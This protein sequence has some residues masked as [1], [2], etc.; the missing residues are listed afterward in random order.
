MGAAVAGEAKLGGDHLPCSHGGI[1][2]GQDRGGKA[3]YPKI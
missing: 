2:T 3:A 1:K